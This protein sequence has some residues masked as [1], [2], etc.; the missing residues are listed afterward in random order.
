MIVSGR[1]THA[2]Q[3]SETHGQIHDGR[4]TIRTFHKM[5]FRID[6]KP[7]FFQGEASIGDGD[8]VTV[9]AVAKGELRAL[10]LR[11]ESTGIEY[12]SPTILYYIMGSFTVVLGLLTLAFLVGFPIL[13]AGGWLFYSGWRNKEALQLL[14]SHRLEAASAGLTAP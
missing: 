5:K 7:A 6:N 3:V 14:R 2:A 4:G 12:G 11:N 10:A 1:V 13:G 8:T 9:A